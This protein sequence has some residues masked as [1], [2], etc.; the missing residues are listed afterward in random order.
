[1][2]LALWS[3]KTGLD[4][5]NTQM[6]I[7]AN[8]LANANTTGFKSQRAAFQDLM[9]QN[10]RQVGAQS[11]QN[12]QYSTGPHARHGRAHRRHR[13]ELLAGQRPPPAATAGSARSPGQRILPDHDAGRHAR[14]H[15]RRLVHAG[16]PGQCGHG[17][18][19][20]DSARDH[21]SRRHAVGH[22]GQRRRGHG[23]VRGRQDDSDR[24]G[25][26]GGLHQRAGPAAHRQQ[27]GGRVRGE[28]L[29]ADRH[30]RAPTA[31]APSSRARSRPRTSTRSPSSST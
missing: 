26:A 6:A 3:A 20:P 21:H 11:T 18:R 8:N 17:E 9:Y 1:M 2:N 15:A 30:R 4:A 14:L 13:E 19:L 27:P 12:T 29:A 22:G 25:A 28:R 7:I 23:R 5:Q 16:Q 31:S 10:V 24:A